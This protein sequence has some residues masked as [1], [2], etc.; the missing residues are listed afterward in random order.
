[1]S[2]VRDIF[3]N[4]ITRTVFVSRGNSG[5]LFRS[6]AA[7]ILR[8]VGESPD[9]PEYQ[10]TA[11]ILAVAQSLVNAGVAVGI[12]ILFDGTP[13]LSA[14]DTSSID[15]SEYNESLHDVR[16]CKGCGEAISDWILE[17]YC[18]D[19]FDARFRC[20][21]HE[22]LRGDSMGQTVYCDGTCVA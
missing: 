10:T 7:D 2:N 9:A 19:C 5:R 1:M 6:S 16:C 4:N 18:A 22:S 17:D 14:G 12:V 15:P 11:G 3:D 13:I 8:R 21:G 20:Q